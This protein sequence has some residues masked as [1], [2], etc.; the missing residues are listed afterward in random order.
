MLLRVGRQ[1]DLVRRMTA[2]KTSKAQSFGAFFVSLGTAKL[3]P[4]VAARAKLLAERSGT[5]LRWYLLDEPE[6]LNL[7]ILS[8]MN[9]IAADDRVLERSLKLRS[10]IQG[11]DRTPAEI[12]PVSELLQGDAFRVT[13]ADLASVYRHNRRFARMCENQ[14]FINLHPILR[15]RGAKNSRTP[16][17]VRLVHYVLT[18][19]ALKLHLVNL[20]HCDVEYGL[21]REMRVWQAIAA[22]E[23]KEIPHNWSPPQFVTVESDDPVKSSLSLEGVSFAYSKADRLHNGLVNANLKARG[24]FGILGPNGSYKTT[25]LRIIAGHLVP[26][27]GKIK[28]D[29]TEITHLPPERRGVVTVFQDFALFPHLSGLDNVLEGSRLLS[30]YSKEQKLWLAEMHMRRL[31][32]AHCANR[33]PRGMSGGEQQKIAIARALMAEP[34][35]LLLDEPTAALDTLQR[36]ALAKLLKQLSAMDAALV[37]L[38]VSHDRDF[39]VSVAENLAVI[40]RGHILATGAQAEL[41]SNPPSA[42][43]AE[44]LGTHN[45]VSGHLSSKGSFVATRGTANLNL[46]P[47]TVPSDLLDKD[48]IVL[49]RRDA[50]L[51]VQ[52]AD[53]GNL[54][55]GRL[56]AV[57]NEIA[58]RGAVLQASLC[59]EDNFEFVALWLRSM[60]TRDMKVGDPIDL[61]VDA[62]ALTIVAN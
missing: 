45:V 17:V 55:A 41:M 62:N 22:G 34:K 53:P 49:I 30:N 24:I 50:F 56:R 60:I 18:E 37:T 20:G 2:A 31:G 54:S 58:D 61:I 44:I 12:V 52:T 3:T 15:R 1:H 59:V 29:S 19:I 21:T 25:L 48:C 9:E 16:I 13:L 43:V 10:L 38:L 47:A 7:M 23:F 39:V 4:Q 11:S 6:K 42:R 35:V 57:V 40:D 36:E 5:R 51:P 28:I 26:S 8:G 33:L 46:Q 27:R 32:V 14:V